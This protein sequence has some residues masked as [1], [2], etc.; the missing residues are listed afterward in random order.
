[1]SQPTSVLYDVPGPRQR[2]ITLISS[3][4]ATVVLLVAAYVLVYLPMD[5]KGQLSMDLW[6]PTPRTRT[7]PRSGTGSASV[8]RTR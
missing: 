4:V 3:I 7:S 1:M 6:G 2:R 5:A 8:S